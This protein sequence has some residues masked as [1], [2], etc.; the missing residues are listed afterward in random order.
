MMKP[1]AGSVE[2]SV[3]RSNVDGEEVATGLD[4]PEKCISPHYKYG[5]RPN[6]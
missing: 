5:R 6:A 4:S 2:S 1:C 3:E